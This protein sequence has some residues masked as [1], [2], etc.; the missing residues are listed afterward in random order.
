M[1]FFKTNEEAL[2]YFYDT[3]N[4]LESLSESILKEG[5]T[6]W[7]IWYYNKHDQLKTEFFYDRNKA[8]QRVKDLGLTEDEIE[9]VQ[10]EGDFPVDAKDEDRPKPKEYGVKM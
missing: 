5:H 10:F 6:R 9:P 4:K 3:K 2:K 1:K 7:K 8:V